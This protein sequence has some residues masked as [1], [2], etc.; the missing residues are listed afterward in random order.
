MYGRENPLMPAEAVT[1]VANS[2]AIVSALQ[3]ASAATGS[4]FG[5]LLGTAIRESG[6][7]PQAQSASSS[8]TGLFQF[9]EQTWLGLVKEYGARHGLASYAQA[10]GKS[11]DGRYRADSADDRQ[12]I[13]ALRND[14]SVS[15]LMAGEYAGQCK[16]HMEQTL[17]RQVGNGELYA[18]HFLGADSAC[19]LIRLCETSPD[20]AAANVFPQAA[21]ANKS[22]FYRADGSSRT[23]REVYDW[24]TQH[25]AVHVAATAPA[26]APAQ[27]P[28]MQYV[29]AMAEFE[30]RLLA[31]ALLSES[32]SDQPLGG[33]KSPFNLSYG[34]L[35]M[36]AAQDGPAP[37]GVAPKR[38]DP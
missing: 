10:I 14:P 9:V 37:G 15:A 8:A 28:R 20:A 38:G 2:S 19:R 23:V 7:K 33:F 22:V 26:P 13:L 21:S 25:P 31:S 11:A 16:S 1:P 18:A 30:T 29:G 3:K 34:V 4:D 35:D 36:L 5:Y 24:A 27:T 12:A 6:L 17:G 32:S